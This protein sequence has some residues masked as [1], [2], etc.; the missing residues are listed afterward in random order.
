MSEYFQVGIVTNDLERSMET[1]SGLMGHSR[2]A[3]LDTDYEARFREEV[4]R[5]QNRNVFIALAPGVHFEII[6]P[7]PGLGIQRE[8]LEQRGPGVFHLGYAADKVPDAF[9]EAGVVFEVLAAGTRFLDT[10]DSLG[11]YLEVSAPERAARIRS[12][13]DRVAG[14]E[15]IELASVLAELS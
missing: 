6:E 13:V 15:D 1:Y 2:F 5:I 8:W 7:G 14:G 9:A 11:Y 12:W 3:R 10:I 4:V